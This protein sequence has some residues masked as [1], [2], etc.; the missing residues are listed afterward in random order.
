MKKVKEILKKFLDKDVIVSLL[1]I[2][3]LSTHFY[4]FNYLLFNKPMN[5][6]WADVINSMF[7]LITTTIFLGFV[8]IFLFKFITRDAEIVEKWA[9]RNLTKVCYFIGF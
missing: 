9:L 4:Y 3:G 2:I 7:L 5:P 6:T 8:F 1:L